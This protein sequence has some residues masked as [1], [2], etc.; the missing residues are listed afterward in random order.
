[1]VLAVM[2]LLGVVAV[3]VV[4]VL[5][6][7]RTPYVAVTVRVEARNGNA[8]STVYFSRLECRLAFAGATLAVLRAYP[9]RVPARGV[10]P[11][12]YVARA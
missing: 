6:Q 11:L 12:A 4:V 7:P 9:F 2:V 1:M 5:L 8:H 3:L 10:L